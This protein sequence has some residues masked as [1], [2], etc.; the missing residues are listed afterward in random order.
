MKVVG[1]TNLSILIPTCSHCGH[2]NV[3]GGVQQVN[4][5][6]TYGGVF[7]RY[8]CELCHG[9]NREFY[10]TETPLQCSGSGI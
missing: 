4:W 3:K 5:E 2:M 6:H 7:Y 10:K 1:L 9:G 8:T